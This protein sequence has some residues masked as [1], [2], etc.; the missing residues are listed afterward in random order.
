M[1][2]AELAVAGLTE[3]DIAERTPLTGGT[4]NA[5]YL[6]RLT[7][8]RRL[9]LK[10]PPPPDT[11]GLTHER[12]LLVGEAEFY[13]AAARAGVPVPAVVSWN[14]DHLLMTEC[15]GVSWND[16]PPT[17]GAE[18]ARLRRELGALVRRL[19]AVHGP[20]FGYPSGAVPPSADWRGTFTAMLDAVLAD[21]DRYAAPLPVPTARIRALASAVAP[22]L[23]EVTTPALVH[24]DLWAGNVLL[25]DGRISALIDGER[26][27]WGDPLADFASL[28]LLAPLDDDLL[29]GYGAAAFSP[30]ERL[31]MALYRTYLDVI[32][33]TEGA[34]R[35]YPAAHVA[36]TVREVT[37][38]L[39]AALTELSVA[40]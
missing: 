8:G 4:Y 40:A 35:A 25:A 32:M 3:A 22:V 1:A 39:R 2:S 11:P 17:S 16:A 23:D 26:M 24:F 34:P 13:R 20:G 33:L 36:R 38:H 9:V 31:R 15:P 19:H 18:R 28:C 30:A 6:L 14:E 27:F 12:R 21:A 10:Q 5:L 37:P 29:A 7:D